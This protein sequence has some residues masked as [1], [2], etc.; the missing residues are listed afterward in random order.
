[1]LFLNEIAPNLWTATRS[2]RFL[3][4]EVGCR[5]TVVRL[6][7]QALVLISP[8]ALK[9]GDRALLDSLGTVTHLV[10][11]NLFHHLHFGEA[12]AIYPN[13][14]AWGVAGLPQKR[15]DL[16]FDALLDQPGNFEETLYYQPFRGFSS[17]L[18]QGIQ[19]AHE[20][21][22]W[23]PPSGSV[24]LTDIAFNFDDTFPFTSRLAAQLL[25]TY[26]TLRP[27]RLE[28]W[29]T[30]DKAAVE[31]SIRQVLTWEFDRVIPG[32]GAVLETHG[33]AQLQRG[34]EWFLGR[35]LA[36]ANGDRLGMRIE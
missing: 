2:L 4:L 20:T 29:G 8:I 36:P 3:G 19:L 24:I 33:K 14:M 23:H 34:F 5:M 25:G 10:A 31:N 13:A 11:P 21:V 18:P 15:P 28:K 1:M 35:S 16:R 7:S 9:N 26:Q 27:S 30:R 32:H 12:Q 6:P 17:I 22:F